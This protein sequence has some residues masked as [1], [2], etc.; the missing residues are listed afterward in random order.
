MQSRPISSALEVNVSECGKTPATIGSWC[1]DCR[2]LRKIRYT[3]ID[4]G[5]SAQVFNCVI[6]P[7]HN[8]DLP[9]LGIYLLFFSKN[10]IL[11][12]LDFQ[13]LFRDEAYI[14]KYV[15]PL[16]SLRD[17][18]EDLNQNLERKF[19]DANQY[20]YKYL[21]FAQTEAETF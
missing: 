19:Y 18:Y 2:Q 7:T 5:E 9:L 14:A 16:K 15:Q 8:Y 12:V 21:L 4:A 3:N 1:Y 10:K 20:F 17:K 13:P 11:V 6:Y